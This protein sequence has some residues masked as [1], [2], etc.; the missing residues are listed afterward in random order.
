MAGERLLCTFYLGDHYLGLDVVRVQEVVRAEE[1]APVPL[2]NPEASR[3][4]K[5][6]RPDRAP[7][8]TCSSGGSACWTAR[9]GAAPVNVVVQTDEGAV[10]LLVDEID[11]VVEVAPA[12]F[13][14]PRRPSPIVCKR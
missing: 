3:S 7:P 13:D 12:L 2:A 9:E 4:S 11:D 8:L 1:L 10:S 14:L 5:L 6:T